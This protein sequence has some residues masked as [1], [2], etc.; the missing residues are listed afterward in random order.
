MWNGGRVIKVNP[1]TA[2]IIDS[3]PLPRNQ[4][5][6]SLAFGDYQGQFGFYLTTA[7]V[8]LPEVADDGKLLHIN[9]LGGEVGGFIP[10]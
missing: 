1:Q 10:A 4:I 3:I 6:T 5:P 8:G 9:I 2:E 7:N